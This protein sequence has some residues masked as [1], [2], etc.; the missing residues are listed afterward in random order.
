[1]FLC[2][3]T[4]T[5]QTVNLEDYEEVKKTWSENYKNLEVPKSLE[6]SDR[7]REEWVKEDL[8]KTTNA[9]DLLKSEDPQK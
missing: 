1:M 8:G 2:P 9:I 4:N 6:K 5:V 7:T 3:S